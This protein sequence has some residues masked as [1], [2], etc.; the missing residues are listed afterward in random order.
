MTLIIPCDYVDIGPLFVYNLIMAGYA[1]TTLLPSIL[2]GH[3]IVTDPI[4]AHANKLIQLV[5]TTTPLFYVC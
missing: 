3:E 4:Q 1:L 2:S 5:I